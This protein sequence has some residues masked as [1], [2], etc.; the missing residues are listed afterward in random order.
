MTPKAQ[1]TEA[2]IDP[3]KKVYISKE[4]NQQNEKATYRMEENMCKPTI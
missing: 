1:V 4:S 3:K 2:K